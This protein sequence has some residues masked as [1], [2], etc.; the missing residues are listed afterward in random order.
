VVSSP[1]EPKAR[2]SILQADLSVCN[3]Y[4]RSSFQ[5][6]FGGAPNLKG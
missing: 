4:R 5:V 6:Q 2:S 1:N 3:S